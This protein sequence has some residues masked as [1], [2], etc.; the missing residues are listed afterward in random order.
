M[1]LHRHIET[2]SQTSLSYGADLFVLGCLI[3]FQINSS[4]I[5][6]LLITLRGMSEEV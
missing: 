4:A 1:A 5:T 6:I 3:N 2:P